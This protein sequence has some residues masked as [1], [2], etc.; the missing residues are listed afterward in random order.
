MKFGT[1]IFCNVTKKKWS[2]KNFKVAAIWDDDV[3]NY[4]NFFEKSCE[5]WL[6][7]VFFQNEPCDS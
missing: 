5:K 7:Y 6:K 3:T 2:K 1:V 4:L